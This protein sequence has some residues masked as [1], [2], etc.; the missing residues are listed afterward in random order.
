MRDLAEVPALQLSMGSA[1][2]KLTP[3]SEGRVKIPMLIRLI[4]KRLVG[5]VEELRGQEE[6][7]PRPQQESRFGVI[8]AFLGWPCEFKEDCAYPGLGWRCGH[9]RR[10]R[11][12]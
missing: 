2:V 1:V 6:W 7:H 3:S 12:R 8:L 11:G 10:F 4:P 9:R 5:L